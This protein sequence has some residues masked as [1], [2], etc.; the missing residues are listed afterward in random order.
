MTVNELIEELRELGG[1]AGDAQVVVEGEVDPS[2][3]GEQGT[4]VYICAVPSRIVY[5]RG[6]VTIEVEEE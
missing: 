2:D 3:G 1:A 5:E 4:R 6:E